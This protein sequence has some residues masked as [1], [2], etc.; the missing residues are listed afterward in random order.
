MLLKEFDSCAAVAWSPVSEKPS[1]LALG[2]MTGSMNTDFDSGANLQIINFSLPSQNKIEN[3]LKM[4][5][6]ASIPSTERF[7]KICWE[8]LL[9]DIFPSGIIVGAFGS[10]TINVWNANTILK[11]DLF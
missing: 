5:S 3:S 4:H 6:I 8:N 9:P 10:G 2:T 7:N 1:F 11:Y